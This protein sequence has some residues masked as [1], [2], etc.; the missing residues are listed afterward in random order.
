M[1]CRAIR[2]V[3]TDNSTR[4]ITGS[5]RL[6]GETM[7]IARA[8]TG[9]VCALHGVP[10][11]RSMVGSFVGSAIGDGDGAGI[12]EA[13]GASTGDSVGTG[14]GAAVGPGDGA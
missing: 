5:A 1:K 3:K 13:V 12:G 11:V 14:T 8:R 7:Y 2:H 4:M 10:T 6:L 9:Y